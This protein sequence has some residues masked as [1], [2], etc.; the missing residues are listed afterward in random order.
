[1]RTAET[2]NFAFSEVQ[3]GQRIGDSNRERGSTSL[4]VGQVARSNA[5]ASLPFRVLAGA[6]AKVDTR[7]RLYYTPHQNSAILAREKRTRFCLSLAILLPPEPVE[8]RWTMLTTYKAIL[9]DNRL[10]WRGIIPE[11]LS[12][13]EAVAVHVTILDEPVVPLV[14]AAQ[15]QR[16]AAALEQLAAA[17]SLAE[18]DDPMA[19]EQEMRRDRPLP[20]RKP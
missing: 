6:T 14:D 1:M 13:D 20:G 10:E 3:R 7:P 4:A 9:R 2:L 18:L 17:N 5:P 8:S 15:G 11:Q 19:W 12:P 16:M